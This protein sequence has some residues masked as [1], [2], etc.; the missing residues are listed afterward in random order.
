MMRALVPP[1][2]L[3][4]D[5]STVSLASSMRKKQSNALLVISMVYDWPAFRNWPIA[6]ERDSVLT[7]S[8]GL[9][10][11]SRPTLTIWLAGGETGTVGPGLIGGVSGLTIVFGRVTFSKN[12]VDRL[13]V[14][15]VAA[16]RTSICAGGAVGL[17]TIS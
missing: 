4:S 5:A 13:T 6:C 1:P 16:T 11:P 10:V 14:T 9:S 7:R 2:E 12:E 8:N 3:S 17:A 15:N